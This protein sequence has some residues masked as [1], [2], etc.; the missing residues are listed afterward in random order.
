MP[1]PAPEPRLPQQIEFIVAVDRLK[2]VFRR[3]R[4]TD[5]SRWENDAE[6]SW[7]LALMAVVLREHAA[8]GVDLCKVLTMHV[9]HDLV[10]IDAGD[11]F[12]YDEEANVGK[13]EREAAAAERIFGL[14]PADQ[15]DS[16]RRLWEEF[17]ARETPE[18]RYAAALDR[19]QPLLLNYHMRGVTGWRRHGVRAPQVVDRNQHIADG[20]PA[21]WEFARRLIADSVKEG[22][23]EG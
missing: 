17:E 15:G 8:E 14:L 9:I 12:A 5:D 22:K 20:S 6:H 13:E 16:L 2:Q 19:L 23:L 21:L 3:S 7:H 1:P 4:L 10:E 18:A 11:T